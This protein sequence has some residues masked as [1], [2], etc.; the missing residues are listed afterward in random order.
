VVRSLM[1][2]SGLA[3]RA[4]TTSEAR[5]CC[6]L[7]WCWLT[8]RTV[9]WTVVTVLTTRNAP[10]DVIEWLPLGRQF[11][12]GYPKHPPL[13]A[14]LT[15]AS[16]QLSPGDVWGVYLLSYGL[17]AVGLWAAWRLG[18]EFLFPRLALA[19]T[20]SLDGLRYLTADPAE[21]NHNITLDVAWALTILCFVRA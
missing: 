9:S 18:Q 12:W 16:A 5:L 8:V 19:A 10:L 11:S 3:N 21:F 20:M 17:V 14:W 7:F 1:D 4:T 15:A 13:P 2:S 6:R